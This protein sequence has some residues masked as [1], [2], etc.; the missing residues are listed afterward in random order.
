MEFRVPVID[1]AGQEHWVKARADR[2]QNSKDGIV[3]KRVL[4]EGNPFSRLEVQ[5][6]LEERG[7]QA[8][9]SDGIPMSSPEGSLQRP[10]EQKHRFMSIGTCKAKVG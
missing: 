8:A 5:P 6:W 7:L 9:E 4:V 2:V 1:K 10:S 3:E